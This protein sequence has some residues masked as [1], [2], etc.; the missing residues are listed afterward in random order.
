M[1]YLFFQTFREYMMILSDTKSEWIDKWRE[2][3]YIGPLWE[4]I[5]EF[6]GAVEF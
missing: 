2:H 5:G 4:G 3:L 6:K 1:G